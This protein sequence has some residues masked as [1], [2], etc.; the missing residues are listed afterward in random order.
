MTFTTYYNGRLGNQII[1]NLAVSLIAEKHNLYVDYCNNQLISELGINLFSGENTFYDT[2]ILGDDNYFEIYNCT[3]LTYNLYPNNSFFQTT[4]IG[5]LLYKYLHTYKIKLNIIN[6]NPF[7][8]RYNTNNDL[9]IHLRL[10]DMV[11]WN[12]GVNYYMNA[13]KSIEFEN[14]YISSDDITHDI[15]K[16]IINYHP[17]TI[18]LDYNEILTIQFASTCKN[19][20]LSQGSFSALI[21]YLSFYSKV[22]YPDNEF[23]ARYLYNINTWIKHSIN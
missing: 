6:K 22:Y 5:N 4:E 20:I 15:I 9:Y 2:I 10:T 16:Q 7:I 8:E 1:R 17:T 14:L 3:N 11:Q 18:I 21:G 23:P 12:P 19:I 13:I